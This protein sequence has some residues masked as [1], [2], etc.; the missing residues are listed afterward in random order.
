MVQEPNHQT[1]AGTQSDLSNASSQTSPSMSFGKTEKVTI[2]WHGLM[3]AGIISLIYLF[4]IL[5]Y[6]QILLLNTNNQYHM[7][8]TRYILHTPG[9]NSQIEDTMNFIYI[10]SLIVGTSYRV[11]KTKENI[12]LSHILEYI[13]YMAEGHYDSR[14][15]ID[16]SGRY[17]HV[18]ININQLMDSMENAL[19]QQYQSERSKDELMTNIGHDL[20]TPLT[21]IVGYLRLLEN[22]DFTDEKQAYQYIQTAYRKAMMMQT[23][24]NDL[25]EYTKSIQMKDQLNRVQLP[26]DDYL[27]QVAADYQIQAERKG[28]EL[29]I[30]VQPQYLTADF[31]PEKMFRAYSNLITN[32]LKYGTG[33]T[34]IVLTA[35]IIEADDYIPPIEQTINK[36]RQPHR[37]RQWL[38]LQ[39]RNNGELVSEEE[40]NLIFKRSYRGNQS[41]A[42][43]E[44]GS[45][46]GLSIVRNLVEAHGGIT[47]ASIEQDEM[48]FHIDLPQS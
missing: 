37:Y 13:E 29:Y 31:D 2:F 20:R 35:R 19:E 47:Y 24:V 28:I 30:D 32:A 6:R 34:K 3:T 45:G 11:Y 33:A 5:S 39:V 4:V 10:I 27:S 18:A 22:R 7:S 15:P 43:Y 12:R 40:L 48:V 42:D 41:R 8:I 46:L 17:Y 23:L 14:I 26:L 25:F 21:S 38:L 1:D 36:S 16:E 44:T 9:L